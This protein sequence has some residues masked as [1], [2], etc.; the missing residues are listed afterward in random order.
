MSINNLPICWY[1]KENKK[2]IIN[3]YSFFYIKFMSNVDIKI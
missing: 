1:A 3:N 2:L